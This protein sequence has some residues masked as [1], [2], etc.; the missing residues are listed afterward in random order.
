MTNSSMVLRD[1]LRLVAALKEARL[2]SAKLAA[3]IAA[4][5]EV[6]R[7]CQCSGVNR[8]LYEEIFK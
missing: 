4:I 2:E 1:Q 7:K 6:A 8:E 3:K 5:V